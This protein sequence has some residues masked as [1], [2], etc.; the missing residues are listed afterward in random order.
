MEELLNAKDTAKAL[1]ITV[2]TLLAWVK[3]RKIATVRIGRHY[4]F[5]KSTITR[6]L[7]PHNVKDES[8]I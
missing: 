5:A 4:K 3:E 7:T 8:F 6:I 2:P 1:N